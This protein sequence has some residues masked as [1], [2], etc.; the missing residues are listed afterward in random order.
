MEHYTVVVSATLM[1]NEPGIKFNMSQHSF[2]YPSLKMIIDVVS[3]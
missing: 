2:L 3:L 1:E